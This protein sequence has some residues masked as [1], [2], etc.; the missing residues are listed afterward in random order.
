M[1]K[2][3]KTP[4]EVAAYADEDATVVLTVRARRS[5]L[6][7]NGLS[8][9]SVASNQIVSAEVIRTLRVGDTVRW[10]NTQRPYRRVLAV[11]EIGGHKYIGFVPFN[12]DGHGH[13]GENFTPG[14]TSMKGC[15]TF[16]PA[17][18]YERVEE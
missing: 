18:L 17:A 4:Y 2:K 6:H 5:D 9:V 8:A 1:S 7:F 10:K 3:D 14:D 16:A 11:T 15:L 13:E 12:V